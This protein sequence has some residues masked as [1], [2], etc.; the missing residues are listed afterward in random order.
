M[1]DLVTQI[2]STD[3]E[4]KSLIEKVSRNTTGACLLL[5]SLKPNY[6]K[7][8]RRFNFKPVFLCLLYIS[9][10]HW[11]SFIKL[12]SNINHIETIRRRHAQS[13]QLKVKVKFEGLI[14]ALVFSSPLYSFCA[15]WRTIM[16]LVSNVYQSETMC[17]RYPMVKVTLKG[18]AIEPWLSCKFHIS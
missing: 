17:R 3:D 15:L 12:S 18:Q 16:K 4:E 10:I 9:Y 8:N 13:H 5:R 1:L 14:I 2:G 11:W 7:Y 6:I